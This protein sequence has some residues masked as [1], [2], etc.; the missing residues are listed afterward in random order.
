MKALKLSFVSLAFSVFLP[1]CGDDDSDSGP[2]FDFI[3]QDLQGSI[4]GIS[5][6][7]KG[8]FFDEG[9]DEGTISIRL[10]DVSEEGDICEIFGNESVSASAILPDEIGIH[11][12]FFDISSFSGIV[13]NLVNPN[14]ED[15][16]PQNNLAFIG[17]VEILSISETQITGRMDATLDS[18]NTVN[19][20]F[21]VISCDAN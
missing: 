2:S 4:D 7:S 1:A 6:T 13:V 20:N 8:G 16:I 3:D 10:Y 17:A 9:F 18:D 19:G 11:E 12:L 14:G 5:F 21:T 15:G